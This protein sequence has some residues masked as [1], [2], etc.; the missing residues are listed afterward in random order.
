[1]RLLA[2]DT[3]TEWCSAALWLDGA[4]IGR[5]EHAGQRHSELLMPMLWA[6]LREAD[7]PLTALDGIAYGMGPGSFTGLRI[8][9]GVA[10]GLALGA[11]VPV[12]GVSTLEAVAEE[13]RD[14]LSARSVLVCLDA[15]M[16]EIYAGLYARDADG[17]RAQWPPRVCAPEALEIIPDADCVGAGSG[18]AAYAPLAARAGATLRAVAPELFPHA[19]AIAR[20]AAPRFARGEAGPAETAQPLYVRDRV[21]LTIREREARTNPAHGAPASP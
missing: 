15:R 2:F 14:T 20:L 4:L 21:A 10:Q 9:C 12:L 7:C 3:A 13:A 1:M 16:Q 8:A 11:D 19:R 17:W 6:L 18:F 5:A